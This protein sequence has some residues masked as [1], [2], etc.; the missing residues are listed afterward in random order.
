L[1]IQTVQQSEKYESLK[2]NRETENIRDRYRSRRSYSDSVSN[3]LSTMV[4]FELLSHEEKELCISLKV[5]PKQYMVSKD[6]CIR[7]CEISDGL[8]KGVA[9]K[10][11]N[12]K[13]V[14]KSSK[15]YDFFIDSGWI[16]GE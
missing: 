8:K 7:Q 14:T 9:M 10:L 12:L 16:T 11:L 3:D 1:G 6:A 15:L 5:S 2:K 4:G 13:D